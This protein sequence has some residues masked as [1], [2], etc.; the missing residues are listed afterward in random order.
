MNC[1]K[2]KSEDV[3]WNPET[4]RYKCQKC[5]LDFSFKQGVLQDIYAVD[6]GFLRFTK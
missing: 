6:N 3:D 2:C 1:P 4:K 5:G